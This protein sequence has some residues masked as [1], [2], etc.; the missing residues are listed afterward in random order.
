[1]QIFESIFQNLKEPSWPVR[2][3][4]KERNLD[5]IYLFTIQDHVSVAGE[6]TLTAARG[7]GERLTSREQI[8]S[9]RI[10]CQPRYS[11]HV[12]CHGVYGF[13]WGVTT[14]QYQFLSEPSIFIH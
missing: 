2:G 1:M 6:V 10:N 13:A 14:S 11:I 9:M 4:E 8:E 5:C 3:G 7:D 12:G